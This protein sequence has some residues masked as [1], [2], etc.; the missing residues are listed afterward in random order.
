M[1]PSLPTPKPEE[2]GTANYYSSISNS[3]YVFQ[4]L[5]GI[6]PPIFQFSWF[7][8][9]FLNLFPEDRWSFREVK[10]DTL[11]SILWFSLTQLCF[12]ML[13]FI[14]P[15][16]EV[17]WYHLFSHFTHHSIPF[18]HHGIGRKSNKIPTRS[19]KNIYMG[20]NHISRIQYLD[21]MGVHIHSCAYICHSSVCDTG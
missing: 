9:V 6:Y 19:N 20:E 5:S 2:W 13:N 14:T 12:Y 3:A 18:K 7:Y 10:A 21:T 16:I 11:F 15:W 4:L 17:S 8:E 1:L